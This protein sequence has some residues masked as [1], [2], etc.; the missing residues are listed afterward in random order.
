MLFCGFGLYGHNAYKK[1]NLIGDGV[2]PNTR[3]PMG[4]RAHLVRSIYPPPNR[5]PQAAVALG[6]TKGPTPNIKLEKD[7]SWLWRTRS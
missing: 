3:R 1:A 2:R 7:I 4:E 5:D 6:T